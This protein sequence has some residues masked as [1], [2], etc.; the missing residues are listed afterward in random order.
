MTT[1]R[2][3]DIKID[4]RVRKDLGDLS[5]LTESIRVHGLL[6]PV[7]IDPQDRLIAGARRLEAASAAG[8]TSVPVFR[9]S[10]LDDALLKLTAERD[11]N[12]CRKD[13]TPGEAV[14]LG[15]RLEKLERP[16]AE[17]RKASAITSRD[18]KGR[19]KSTGGKLPPVAKTRD[20][21]GAAVGMSGKNYEK[22]KAVVKAAKAD[23]A[24]L[25]ALNEMNQTG[26]VSKA[27][28]EVKRAAII[29][30]VAAF[31][32][33][34]FRVIYADPPWKYGST[35][36]TSEDLGGMAA[37]NNYPTMSIDELCA[38]PVCGIVDKDAVLFLWITSPLL[39]EC[40]PV[41]SAW[42]F[43]YKASYIWDKGGGM[44]GN[45]NHVRHELLLVCTR[46][47]CLPDI[48]ERP[49]SIQI[50]KRTGRHSEKPEHFRQ[51]IDRMYPHGKRIEMF[52][53]KKAD[54]WSAWGNEV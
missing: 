4:D 19:A 3:H 29:K 48:K 51:L 42:G 49:P 38:L 22:A 47:S 23:A 53:R 34:K 33:E 35:F 1:L 44:P 15:E 45:Y 41:I 46:G 36:A 7:V 39:F 16:K 10:T 50:I 43:E 27:F 17:K 8:L 2:I 54:G 11:E 18:E 9:V 6:Q 31:P 12:I 20:A 13:F 37:E 25:P 40:A 24:L 52:A 30:R 28:R 26:N 5:D 21:V 14:A 32:S